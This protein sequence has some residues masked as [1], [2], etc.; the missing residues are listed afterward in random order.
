V[1]VSEY[2]FLDAQL[3]FRQEVLANTSPDARLGEALSLL[4]RQ[5][6]TQSQVETTRE[7]LE[8]LVRE[9][10]REPIGIE[11]RYH[12]ARL[13]HLHLIPADP[14][15]A[16]LAYLELADAF[17]D[18]PLAQQALVKVCLM[19]IYQA[20]P[21]RRTV[22]LREKES[23]NERFTDRSAIRDYHLALG[24]AY[25]F[26]KQ[27]PERALHHLLAAER[28][29]VVGF[30]SRGDVLVAIGDLASELSRP[31]IA[32]QAFESF[33]REYPRDIRAYT[34]RQ[35]AAALSAAR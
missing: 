17:P 22:A 33:V 25:V 20:E 15:R 29:G 32:L 1:A 14:A 35:R 11:A 6:R 34:I 24:Y 21:D 30:R 3:A 16:R 18:N 4:N 26:F 10:P 13:D 2:R 23:W 27:A 31:E 28:A 9:Y 8:A 5:P 12:L 7:L 19:D